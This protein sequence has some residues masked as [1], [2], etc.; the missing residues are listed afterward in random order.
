MLKNY[1]NF[2][3]SHTFIRV[4]FDEVDAKNCSIQFIADSFIL[5]CATV[6]ELIDSLS[7]DYGSHQSLFEKRKLIKWPNKI[8]SI[9]FEISSSYNR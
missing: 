4:V 6:L 2:I 1:T 7:R 3:T 5:V 8:L 9:F